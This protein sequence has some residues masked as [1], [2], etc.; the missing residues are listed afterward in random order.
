MRQ[1]LQT[2]FVYAICICDNV[3]KKMLW[4]AIFNISATKVACFLIGPKKNKFQNKVIEDI[5]LLKF[6]DLLPILLIVGV[7]PIFSSD[8]LNEI[9]NTNQTGF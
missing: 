9:D 6:K 1:T 7:T 5:M 8:C 4:S 3:L 2:N